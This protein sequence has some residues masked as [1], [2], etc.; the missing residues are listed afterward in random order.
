MRSAWT[1]TLQLYGHKVTFKLDTF[2]DADVLPFSDF[3]HLGLTLAPARSRLVSY[4]GPVEE[5]QVQ[6]QGIPF[7]IVKEVEAI[8]GRR[9]CEK[10]GL[11]KRVQSVSGVKECTGCRPSCGTMR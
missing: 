3:E 9:S 4:S 6:V 11:L 7:H 8:L 5:I 1:H 2:S 10:L